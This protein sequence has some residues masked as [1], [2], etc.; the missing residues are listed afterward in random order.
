MKASPTRVCASMCMKSGAKRA[1]RMVREKETHPDE[2]P[3]GLE[4][5]AK[6]LHPCP[7]VC[8]ARMRGSRKPDHDVDAEVGDEHA[9]R[10]EQRAPR[11]QRIV[12][13]LNRGE[14]RHTQARGS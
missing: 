14:H 3:R 6:E 7:P 13:A 4:Q 11:D 12:V 9:H 10:D 1:S 8:A 2:E 5:T